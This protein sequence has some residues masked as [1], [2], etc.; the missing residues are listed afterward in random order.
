MN[1]DNLVSLRCCRPTR[2]YSSENRNCFGYW[3]DLVGTPVV[4]SGKDYF[5]N[6]EFILNLL[7]WRRNKTPLNCDNSHE[8]AVW[9]GIRQLTN[10]LP[11][12]QRYVL[13]FVSEELSP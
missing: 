1:N 7:L 4:Q 3:S 8:V 13:E 2:S 5:L 6:L 12:R 10:R 11:E 9:E